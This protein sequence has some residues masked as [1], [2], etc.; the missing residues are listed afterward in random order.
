VLLARQRARQ[1][2]ALCRFESHDQA[3]IAAGTFAVATEALRHSRSS[4]LRIQIEGRTLHVFSLA[5]GG[6]SSTS[7]ENNAAGTA[8]AESSLRLVKPLPAA[9]SEMSA[10]DI[11]WI[12]KQ[13]NQ[14]G[15]FNMFEEIR[16]QNQEMLALL[17]ALHRAQTDLEQ[18]KG[19]AGAP[20]AA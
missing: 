6:S 19:N 4:W 10:E 5:Q 12:T 3:C 1:I 13:L 15:S 11:A 9:A 18:L 20:A 8:P 14:E 16:H 2:A 17:H 7:P